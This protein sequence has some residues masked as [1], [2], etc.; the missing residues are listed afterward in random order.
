MLYE[1]PLVEYHNRHIAFSEIPRIFF[2]QYDI[3]QRVRERAQA[4][5]LGRVR[6]QGVLE[7]VQQVPREVPSPPE[8]AYGLGATFG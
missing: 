2:Y 4:V 3:L 7:R 6:A 5:D 8:K 1:A